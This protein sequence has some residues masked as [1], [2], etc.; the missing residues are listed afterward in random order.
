VTDTAEPLSRSA[1]RPLAVGTKVEVKQRFDGRF[2]KGFEVASV[3]SGGYRLRRQS[4]GT[5]LPV[6]FARAEIRRERHSTWWR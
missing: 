5:V 6:V 3:D 4:D 1:P 2:T